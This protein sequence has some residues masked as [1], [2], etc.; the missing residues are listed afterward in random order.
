MPYLSRA[1]HLITMRE[2]RANLRAVVDGDEP[3]ILGTHYRARALIIPVS[4]GYPRF[5][6]GQADT[7]A[8][9]KRY[10]DDLMTCIEGL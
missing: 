2:V 7:V 6:K 4:N 8:K 5:G 3:R 10:F 1:R 9:I